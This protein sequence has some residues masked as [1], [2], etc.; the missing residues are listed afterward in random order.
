[1]N[2]LPWSPSLCMGP[3]VTLS[4]GSSMDPSSTAKS[5]LRGRGRPSA[6]WASLPYWTNVWMTSSNCLSREQNVSKWPKRDSSSAKE[7]PCSD[8]PDRYEKS[9]DMF[10]LIIMNDSKWFKI[11]YLFQFYIPNRSRNHISFGYLPKMITEF[12]SA[13]LLCDEN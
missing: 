2:V 8:S 3:G 7:M 5:S 1:M 13:V 9:S 6:F 12:T 11:I 4:R 10:Y